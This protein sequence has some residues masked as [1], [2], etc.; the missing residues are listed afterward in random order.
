[1]HCFA[2]FSNCQKFLPLW[3]A[4]LSPLP[5]LNKWVNYK[6]LLIKS[7]FEPVDLGGFNNL[8]TEGSYGKR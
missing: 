8:Q 3:K 4:L 2:T 6:E 5:T 7:P 1:M